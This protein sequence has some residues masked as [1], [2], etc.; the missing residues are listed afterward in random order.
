MDHVS[1]T[2]YYDAISFMNAP[3][4]D[5][6]VMA[7]FFSFLLY[8]NHLI[9][10]L[11]SFYLSMCTST[12]KLHHPLK[13]KIN[14]F[15][16]LHISCLIWTKTKTLVMNKPSKLYKRTWKKERE[17]SNQSI[18]NCIF[19]ITMSLTKPRFDGSFYIDTL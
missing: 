15:K 11:N 3:K 4:P 2:F 16:P 13:T 9:S 14:K 5:T 8:S 12:F 18:I 17:N 6:I 19:L 1:I 10:S 7:S